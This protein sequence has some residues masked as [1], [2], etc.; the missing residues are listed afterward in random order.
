[1]AKKKVKPVKVKPKTLQFHKDSDQLTALQALKFLDDFRQV[2]YGQ[3][4]KTKLISLRV[5]ENLLASFKVKAKQQ[6]RKYQSVIVQL[7]RQW[8][9]D[10]GEKV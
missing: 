4:S 3:E 7:M 8:L 1:M 5:P 9:K 2:V 6:D 10:S